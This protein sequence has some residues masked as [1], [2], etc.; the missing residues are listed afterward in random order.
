VVLVNAVKQQ[1]EQLRRQQQEIDAL[2]A[3]FCQANPEA[4]LCLEGSPSRY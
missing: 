3:L 4:G 1:Q 2:K